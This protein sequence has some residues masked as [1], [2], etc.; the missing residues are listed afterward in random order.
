MVTGQNM[1]KAATATAA[2]TATGDDDGLIYRRPVFLV[3]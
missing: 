1:W 2:I 3:T